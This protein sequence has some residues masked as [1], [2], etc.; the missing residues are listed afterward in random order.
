MVRDN[1]YMYI[2]N[3]R[4]EFPQEAPLDAI[5]SPSY[6]D[7][8][9]ANK[10]KSITKIQSEIFILPRPSEELYDLSTDPYQFNNLLLI[11]DIPDEYLVLKN[12]LDDWIIETDDNIPTEL[13]KDWYLRKQEPFNQSSLL[14]TKFHGVRGTMPG[15]SLDAVKNNSKGP[16]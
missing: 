1:R 6:I 3:S 16:F 8:K 14:K 7:L 11:D 5:N 4:P 9:E 2:K 15:S 10:N 12:V 13:T